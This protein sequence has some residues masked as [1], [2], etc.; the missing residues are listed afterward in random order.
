MTMDRPAVMTMT[1]GAVARI[2]TL[3]ARAEGDDVLGVRIGVSS[4]GCSGLSYTMD[5][6]R[7]PGAADEIVEKDGVKVFIGPDAVFFLIGTQMDYVEDSLQSGF[8]FTN[9]NATGTCGCGESFSVDR[10]ELARR[11]A[12]LSA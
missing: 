12:E 4:K 8:S 7:E 3:L 5:Y 6:V 2:K 9:P 10:E 1:D 11:Q